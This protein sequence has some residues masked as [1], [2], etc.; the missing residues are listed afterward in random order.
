[1]KQ[2]GNVIFYVKIMISWFAGPFLSC[3]TFCKPNFSTSFP[4]GEHPLPG[5]QLCDSHRLLEEE[6]AEDQA[7][8]ED[9]GEKGRRTRKAD[10]LFLMQHSRETL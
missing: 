3:A 2:C 1:M 8:Q 9:T 7:R 10:L 5:E 4:S 6:R